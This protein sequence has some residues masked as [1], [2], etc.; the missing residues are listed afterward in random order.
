MKKKTKGTTSEVGAAKRKKVEKAL[1]LGVVVF[2]LVFCFCS[3]NFI[4]ENNKKR[5]QE[6]LNS[7]N[8]YY[9]GTIWRRWRR[10]RKIENKNKIINEFKVHSYQKQVNSVFC[11]F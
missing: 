5:W 3:G 9:V 11:R 7:Y 10:T 2:N 6:V 1:Q 8:N 4:K